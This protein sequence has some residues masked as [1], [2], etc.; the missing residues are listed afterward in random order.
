MTSVYIIAIALY[1]SIIRILASVNEKAKLFVDGRKKWHEVLK[2]KVDPDSTYIWFHCSSL[3]EFEQGRPLIEKIKKELPHY[4]IVLTFFSPSGY[5]IRK[6][7][8]FADIVSY[9][10]TDSI[11]NAKKFLD[12]VKPQKAF[13]IK[14]EF[15]YFYISELK[16][17]N[18]PLY[19]ISGIFRDNQIFFGKTPWGKWFRKMLFNF[20]HIFVQDEKSAELLSG[21]GL[22]NYSVSGD[23]RF[24]RVAEIARNSKD[25]PLVEK[26]KGDAPLIVAGS[27]W[28]TDEDMLAEF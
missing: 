2:A 1:S 10:P 6:N 22:S 24:D 21:E 14:Y 13:F 12:L 7:Y 26:F 28:K 3:G 27:T 4:K 15:W 11:N 8:N 17:R 18:I 5:E 19:L 9:L 20:E 16:K 25:F 23:T